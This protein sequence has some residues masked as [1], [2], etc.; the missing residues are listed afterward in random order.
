VVIATRH[1]SHARYAAAAL[2]A[3]KAVFLEKPLAIDE[4]GLGDVLAAQAETGEILAV[5]FNRRFS[6]LALRLKAAVP[7]DVP[8]AVT[9]RINAGPVPAGSWIHDP[10]D[11]AGRIIGEMCHFVDFLLFLT[12]SLPSEVFAHGLG[13]ATGGLHDTVVASLKFANGSVASLNYFATGD[14]A[15]PKERI[16]VY[17]S[18]TVAVLD[19]F[20]ELSVMRNG[21]RSRYRR[22]SQDKGYDAEVEAFLGALRGER[23]SPIDMTS[24]AATTRVTFDIEESLRTGTPV[25][26][27]FV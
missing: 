9:Y 27:D 15:F 1:G 18:E 17:G 24:L 16:E 5:G 13:G 7:S 8:L 22:L 10:T 25:R 3:G 4:E 14:K 23:A 26:R 12:G 2:R 6:S 21:R 19:D 11:G 20:R